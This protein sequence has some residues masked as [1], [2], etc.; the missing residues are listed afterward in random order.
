MLG[1]QRHSFLSC[2]NCTLGGRLIGLRNRSLR[3]GASLTPHEIVN[4][5][6]F[7]DVNAGTTPGHDDF[8]YRKVS[9]RASV[10]V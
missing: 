8:A 10:N 5:L 9:K 2:F 1:G 6:K 3:E 4:G 7:S